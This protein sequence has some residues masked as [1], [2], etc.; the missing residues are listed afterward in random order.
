MPDPAPATTASQD[1]PVL[2]IYR[3]TTVAFLRK[4]F[5]MA[6]ELGHLPSLL[7]REFFRTNVTLYGTTTFEDAVIFTH[8]V[9]RCLESLAPE[10]QAVVARCVFQEYTQVEAAELLGY[11]L[12]SVERRYGEAL[13]TLTDIFIT[14]GLLQ[15]IHIASPEEVLE[16][17][18]TWKR[19]ECDKI[20]FPPKKTVARAR[21]S[22]PDAQKYSASK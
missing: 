12:R 13:D 10:L 17:L 9:E 11:S 18:E 8:D 14:R 4:Y 2:A 16:R 3:A 19:S 6:V 15:P 21:I 20:E 1:D 5:R 7:G 22:A